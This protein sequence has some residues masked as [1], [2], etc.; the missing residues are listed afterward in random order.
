MA[1]VDSAFNSLR[2]VTGFVPHGNEALIFREQVP[3]KLWD[4]R[5]LLARPH[6]GPDDSAALFTWIGL[7]PDLVLEVRFRRFVGHIDAAPGNVELPAVVDAAQ[8]CFLIAAEKQRGAAV[9]AIV[10]KQ[11]DLAIGV[12]EEN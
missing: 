2:E 4:A 10:R 1:R 3:F 7:L 5:R 6:V 11:S 12:A 8:T 9:G